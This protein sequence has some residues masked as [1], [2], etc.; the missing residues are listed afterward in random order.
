MSADGA[1][2]KAP[3]IGTLSG[4]PYLGS[5]WRQPSGASGG[6]RQ[7]VV[8][9]PVVPRPLAGWLG[10]WRSSIAWGPGLWAGSRSLTS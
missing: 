4:L 7:A 9:I 1:A 3:A 10:P 5:S 2:R 6:N 8:S